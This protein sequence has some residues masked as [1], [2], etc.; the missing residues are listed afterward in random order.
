MMRIIPLLVSCLLLTAQM[1][2]AL[3]DCYTSAQYPAHQ[4]P[5]I[6]EESYSV[7]S[8]DPADEEKCLP[9]IPVYK[10]QP[11]FRQP[12]Y[13][14]MGQLYAAYAKAVQEQN[15]VA[16]RRLN[17]FLRPL[18]RS[19]QLWLDLGNDA[20]TPPP[21]LGGMDMM[22]Q[23]FQF[24]APTPDFMPDAYMDGVLVISRAWPLLFLMTGGTVI[25]GGEPAIFRGS[26]QGWPRFALS[27]RFPDLVPQALD[28]GR[29]SLP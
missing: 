11:L 8:L 7:V 19:F 18:P 28:D 2:H 25:P 12:L 24:L 3:P 16:Q 6:E 9:P 20:V 1:A 13:V 27:W 21:E 5:F 17:A 4:F 23:I 10:G 15:P 22:I 29:L 14:S 26:D